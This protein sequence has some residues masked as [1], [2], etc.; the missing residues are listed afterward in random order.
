VLRKARP[1]SRLRPASGLPAPHVPNTMWLWGTTLILTLGLERLSNAG[2]TSIQTS[3]VV[4]VCLVIAASLMDLRGNGSTLGS[5]ILAILL[6]PAP[7]VLLAA[8]IITIAG[9]RGLPIDV[10]TTRLSLVGAWWLALTVLRP[11]IARLGSRR[12]PLSLAGLVLSPVA[13]ILAIAAYTWNTGPHTNRT[14]QRLQFLYQFEDNAAWVSHAFSVLR[15]GHLPRTG[16]ESEYFGYSP[17]S[18]M[19]GLTGDI[20]LRGA[21]SKHAAT[22][23]AAVDVTVGNE[24]LAVVVAAGLLA[25]IFLAAI[26]WSPGTMVPTRAS[27][28]LLSATLIG[29]GSSIS[30]ATPILLVGHMSLAWAN[31]ALLLLALVVVLAMK[32]AT[33]QSFLPVFVAACLAAYAAAGSWVFLAGTPVA[34][35]IFLVTVH[36]LRPRDASAEPIGARTFILAAGIIIASCLAAFPQLRQSMSAAGISGLAGAQGGVAPVEPLSLAGA[37]AIG[38]GAGVLAY[39]RANLLAHISILLFAAASSSAM[40]VFLSGVIPGNSPTYSLTKSLYVVLALAPLAA[41]PL[42]A[43]AL[44]STNWRPLVVG[45]LAASTLVTTSPTF[46]SVIKW[47]DALAKSHPVAAYGILRLSTQG[48][49]STRIVC[50]P[51]ASIAPYDSYLC[52]RWA[53]ALSATQG[54]AEFRLLAMQEGGSA[55]LEW[56]KAERNGYLRGAT[57]K[58]ASEVVTGQCISAQVV[59]SPPAGPKL[60]ISVSPTTQPGLPRAGQIDVVQHC[61]NRLGVVGWAPFTKANATLSVWADGPVRLISAERISR[62][63][64]LATPGNQKLVAPGFSIVLDPGSAQIHQLCIYLQDGATKLLVRGA[65]SNGCA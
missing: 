40:L 55:P 38:F 20:A 32:A 21:P 31:V 56:A 50:Q 39:W 15:H 11:L 37:I 63:D 49:D 13:G 43:Q 16:A 9:R 6:L 7:T 44:V 4:T 59:K 42:F 24:L 64:V 12:L 17:L 10:G 48:A 8:S 58:D 61:S 27:A 3:A 28:F 26:A 65:F 53:S 51:N 36:R 23:F 34:F 46:G 14:A 30:A 1:G 41:A 47:P 60:A 5:H 54:T 22:A 35:A 29:V 45:V 62:P 19:P 57:V 2:Y 25:T 33:W 18:S 52:N